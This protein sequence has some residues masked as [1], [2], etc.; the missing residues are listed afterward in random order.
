[1]DAIRALQQQLMEAQKASNVRKIS[2]RNCID[3][4]QKLIATDQVKLFHTSN[5]KEYLTPEQLDNEIRDSIEACGGRISVTELPNEIGIALEHVESRV[6]M[7]RKRDSSLHKI[8]NE[9]FSQQYLQQVAQEI[10]ESL[11]ESGCMAVSDLASRYNLPAEYIRNS[12]LVLLSMSE[13]VVRQSTVHTS[14]YAAR[15]EARVRGC[16]RACTEP[17]ALAQL[18]ARHGLDAELLASE[19]QKLIREEVVQGKLQGGTFTPKC[20]TELETK[21]VDSFFECNGY[22]TTSMVKPSGLTLKEWVA[23]RKADGYTLLS[24]FVSRHMVEEVLAAVSEAVAAE[25]WVDAHALLPPALAAAEAAELLLQLSSQKK[26]S[27]SAVLL[28]HVAASNA[29]LQGIAKS[30]DSEV[31]KAAERSLK[32]KAKEEE[33]DSKKKKGAKAKKKKGEEDDAEEPS[34]GKESGVPNDAIL[35]L[36]ADQHPDLPLEVQDDLCAKVQSLLAVQV[37][38]TAEKLR[39]TLQTKQK[40]LFEQADKL[41][42][43]RYE[44][45]VLGSRALGL[46]KLQDSP[47]YQHLLREVVVEPLHALIAVRLEEAT[48]TAPEVTAGNRKQCLDKLAAAEGKPPDSLLRL[49]AALAKKDTKETKEGKDAKDGKEGKEKEKKPKKGEKEDEGEISEVYHAAAD[50]SHIYCRKVDKKREKAAAAEQRAG[51]KERLKELTASDGLAV[52][53]SGLQLALNAEGVTRLVLPTELWALRLAAAALKAEEVRE[54]C[55]AL[56]DLCDETGDAVA[57]EAAAA[58]WRSRFVS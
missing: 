55:V 19:V 32:P 35:N 34:R 10:E 25:S 33:G 17:A 21:K 52:C 54:Q 13:A 6:E 28:E 44:E 49:A 48:G 11:Q 51:L 1:M 20:Y 42:Q 12:V 39:S 9:L 23:Q 43:E 22:L 3:L 38:D 2:E 29:L 4:V 45:L 37:S 5:G 41:V 24:C 58:E 47:L 50:D 40:Q 16:L 31:Q 56:C 18:A 36:L 57:R 30:L 27:N 53:H 46:A 14:S 26:L 15:V 8:H 7:L